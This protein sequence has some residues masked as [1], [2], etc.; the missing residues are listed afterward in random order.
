MSKQTRRDSGPIEPFGKVS[1][2]GGVVA[3]NEAIEIIQFAVETS[4]TK[5]MKEK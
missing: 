1:G 4:V 2:E 3:T 5:Q